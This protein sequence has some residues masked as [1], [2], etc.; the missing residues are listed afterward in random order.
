MLW[1][2]NPNFFRDHSAYLRGGACPRGRLTR[3]GTEARD[4]RLYIVD[5]GPA[6]RVRERDLFLILK[7]CE[8]HMELHPPLL[9]VC[10]SDSNY[11]YTSYTRGLQVCALHRVR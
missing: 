11:Y 7:F 2:T 4:A 1:E 6:L 5:V 8:K 9:P 10:I 3:G